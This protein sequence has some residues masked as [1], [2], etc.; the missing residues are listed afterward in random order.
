MKNGI[1]DRDQVLDVLNDIRVSLLLGHFGVTEL[2]DICMN[3]HIY[4]THIY[5]YTLLI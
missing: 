1:S 3:I 2:D 5:K 4:I